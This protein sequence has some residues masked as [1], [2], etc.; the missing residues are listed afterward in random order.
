MSVCSGLLMLNICCFTADDASLSGGAIAGIVIGTLL[1][2]TFVI[3]FGIVFIYLLWSHK[4]KS[5]YV[6][7][8][9]VSLKK[10]NLV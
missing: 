1:A 4:N 10:L 8:S 6:P 5:K 3:I 2:V 9:R 7:R